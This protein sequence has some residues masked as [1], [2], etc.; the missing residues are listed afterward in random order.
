VEG[1]FFP[2]VSEPALQR[3]QPMLGP[4]FQCVVGR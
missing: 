4:R 1:V 3:S 2:L